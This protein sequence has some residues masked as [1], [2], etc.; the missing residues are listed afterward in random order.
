MSL[1]S[2]LVFGGEA[3]CPAYTVAVVQNPDNPSLGGGF[4]Y[5]DSVKGIT[6][7][8]LHSMLTSSLW[9]WGGASV[10][11]PSISLCSQS[12]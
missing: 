5:P 6:Y 10:P 12:G 9:G 8:A 7:D 2:M 4:V 3:E 1:Y 11:G